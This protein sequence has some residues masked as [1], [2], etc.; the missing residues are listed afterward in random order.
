ML[1]HVAGC[2]SA[3]NRTCNNLITSTVSCWNRNSAIARTL[4][5]NPSRLCWPEL[6]F[7]GPEISRRLRRKVFKTTYTQFE[8]Q[9]DH[10]QNFVVQRCRKRHLTITSFVFVPFGQCCVQHITARLSQKASSA[11]WNLYK[12]VESV[13]LILSQCNQR[14]S[15]TDGPCNRF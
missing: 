8:S 12:S 7:F 13:R 15:H 2:K 10:P 4:R 3:P 9:G 14:R 6:G 5:K 11:S 1:P